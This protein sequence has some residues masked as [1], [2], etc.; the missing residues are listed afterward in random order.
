MHHLQH[1]LVVWLLAQLAQQGDLQAAQRVQIR[2]AQR[3]AAGERAVVGEQG[4][5]LQNIQQGFQ[6]ALVF[7]FDG[8]ENVC[9]VF[10]VLAERGIVFGER[11][12]GFRHHLLHIGEHGA[13]KAVFLRVLL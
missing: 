11:E 1:A 9:A 2:D 7:G 8:G 12:I 10:V 5:G 4:F 3:Q 6:A 13:E